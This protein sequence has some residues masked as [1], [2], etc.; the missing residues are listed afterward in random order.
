MTDRWGYQNFV[1]V[2]HPYT[3]GAVA[4]M[5]LRAVGRG[6]EVVQHDHLVARFG[7]LIGDV[8]A[9]EPGPSGNQY[10]HIGD[11]RRRCPSAP[12]IGSSRHGIV[13]NAH[14]APGWRHRLRWAPWN[15]VHNGWAGLSW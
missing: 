13:R 6:Q 15:G 5:R 3:D 7:Q 2:L 1:V 10:A 12:H 11:V 4:S 14:P 8:G 9:D